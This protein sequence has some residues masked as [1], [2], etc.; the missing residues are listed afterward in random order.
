MNMRPRTFILVATLLLIALFALG[1]WSAFTAPATLNFLFGK[2]EA[3]LGILMLLA[4]GV[5]AVGFMLMLAKAEV[6]M[7]LEHRRLAAELE[8]ARKLAS[9]SET[10][11]TEQLRITLHNDFA[12]TNRKLDRLLEQTRGG[13]GEP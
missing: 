13:R 12:E 3:P 10:S 5:L 9:D 11:R 6:V 7:L 1:N 8:A 2:V 4:M